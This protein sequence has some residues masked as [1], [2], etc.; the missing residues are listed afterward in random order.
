MVLQSLS[1][2]GCG[3]TEVQEVKPDTYFCHHCETVFKYVPPV[4]QGPAPC[5]VVECGVGAIG[6]CYRCKRPFCATH[7][8]RE[9]DWQGVSKVMF[10]DCCVSC[11][12]ADRRQVAESMEIAAGE[13]D[14]ERTIQLVQWENDVDPLSPKPMVLLIRSN[15]WSWP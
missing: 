2:T 4:M 15:G 10:V 11:Q 8:A 3:S 12:E 5:D 6:Q 1:C 14:K 7:Q 9:A 13:K